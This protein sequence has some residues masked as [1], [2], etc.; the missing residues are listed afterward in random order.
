MDLHG[1]KDK[2][3]VRTGSG[4]FDRWSKVVRHSFTNLPTCRR[5]VT[6]GLVRQLCKLDQFSRAYEMNELYPQLRVHLRTMCDWVERKMETRI[7]VCIV[8][9]LLRY[10]GNRMNC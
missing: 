2:W 8:E 6:D 3:L 1:P 4:F 9:V 5:V 7:N 10:V